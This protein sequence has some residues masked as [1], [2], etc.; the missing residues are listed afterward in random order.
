MQAQDYRGLLQALLLL[1][2]ASIITP[3]TMFQY[4]E[5]QRPITQA[6]IKTRPRGYKFFFMLNSTEHEIIPAHKCKNANNCWH[7]NIY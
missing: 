5:A 4:A 1:L 3:C 7:F 6:Y 2:P